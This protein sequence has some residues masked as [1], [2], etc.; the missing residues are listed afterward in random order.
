[1]TLPAAALHTVAAAAALV[2]GFVAS[3]M[4]LTVAMTVTVSAFLSF[5]VSA[6]PA[7]FVPGFRGLF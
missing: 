4:T 3:A 6:A 2:A 1:M 5:P 7:A